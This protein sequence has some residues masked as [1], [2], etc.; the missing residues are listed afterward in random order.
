[1]QK[2]SKNSLFLKSIVSNVLELLLSAGV[3]H[4]PSHL[5]LTRP[6]G[7]GAMVTSVKGERGE[8]HGSESTLQKT[9]SSV[10][11][12][13]GSGPEEIDPGVHALDNI[14]SCHVKYTQVSERP[15]PFLLCGALDDR[16]TG[17]LSPGQNHSG[18]RQQGHMY[19]TGDSCPSP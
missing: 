6:L 13:Q 5:I 1:M 16:L 10:M 3:S 2:D 8:D 19:G 12:E 14:W 4:G 17:H 18:S 11:A 7:A 15:S 9:K